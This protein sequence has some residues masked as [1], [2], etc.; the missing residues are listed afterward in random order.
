MEEGRGCGA[1]RREGFVAHIRGGGCISEVREGRAASNAELE[2]SGEMRVFVNFEPELGREDGKVWECG[3]H[4]VGVG[5]EVGGVVMKSMM[6]R[7]RPSGL[8]TPHCQGRE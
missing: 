2:D 7:W 3:R 8:A 4:G 6:G 1:D 5:G